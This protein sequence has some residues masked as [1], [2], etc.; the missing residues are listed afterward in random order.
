MVQTHL[1]TCCF[2]QKDKW[3]KPENFQQFSTTNRRG[4]MNREVFLRFFSL[5]VFLTPLLVSIIPPMSHAHLHA[6]FIR[7]A[8]GEVCEASNKLMF[9]RRKYF[10]LYFVAEWH[11]SMCAEISAYIKPKTTA[12]ECHSSQVNSEHSSFVS[13]RSKFQISAM[14]SHIVRST[15]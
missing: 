9:F 4:A 2:Y 6:A 5:I 13:R 8:N 15:S 14:R 11:P 12:P 1:H 7:R 10:V 3:A